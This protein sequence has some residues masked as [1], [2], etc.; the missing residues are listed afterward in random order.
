MALVAVLLF[1]GCQNASDSSMAYDEMAEM[2]YE[3]GAV[4]P[5]AAEAPMADAAPMRQTSQVQ[6]D[7]PAPADRQLIRTASVRL[8][9]ED[10]GEA[11]EEARQLV[12][13][14]GGFVGNEDSQRYSDRVE[15]TLTL[16]VPNTQFDTLLTAVSELAGEVESRSVDVDDVT[17]QVADMSARLETKRAAEA[18]YRELLSRSGSIEDILA[19]QTRLQQVREEIES[20]EAQLRALRDQVSL[21]TIRLTV[22]EASAAGITA[23]PGFF[24]RAGRSFVNGWEG[25]LELTLALLTLWPLLLV[26][27]AFAWF[28]R[29]RWHKWK[30]QAKT[31]A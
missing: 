20:T 12:D 17:R 2:D 13:A 16:R 27:A 19:V 23:G 8:R 18:Q 6:V 7:T 25:I 31:A 1:A 11:V 9:A 3:A 21:S 15:T 14:V 28:A 22:F 24:A 4:A 5:M 10:H 29:R 26:G 30:T